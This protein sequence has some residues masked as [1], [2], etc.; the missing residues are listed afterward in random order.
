MLLLVTNLKW[1]NVA[2]LVAADNTQ[3]TFLKD[4]IFWI[5]MDF[6][7]NAWSSWVPGIL[8]CVVLFSYSVW[9]NLIIARDGASG[10]LMWEYFSLFKRYRV[11]HGWPPVPTAYTWS[12]GTSH[13]SNAFNCGA[14]AWSR[15][16]GHDGHLEMNCRSCIGNCTLLHSSILLGFS[17]SSCVKMMMLEQRC[18][19]I[20]I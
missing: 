17:C 5:L 1:W 8:E 9:I 11:Y 19:A 18:H 6:E 20:Q 2:Q 14:A 16:K 10:S 13:S 4:V 15:M 3:H 12:L 7:F